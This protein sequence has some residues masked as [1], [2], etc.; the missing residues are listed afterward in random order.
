LLNSISNTLSCPVDSFQE[1]FGNTM[2]PQRYSANPQLGTWVHTQRRQYKLLSD[3]KKSSM[4]QQKIDSLNALD[5]IWVARQNDIDESS[6]D[7]AAN[8]KKTGKDQGN[9]KSNEPNE[10]DDKKK[11]DSEISEV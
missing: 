7:D 3:G 2:V 4:N 10:N 1:T 5:F 8:T 6:D 11:T 9:L